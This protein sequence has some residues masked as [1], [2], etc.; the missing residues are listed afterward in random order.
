[1]TDI[2]D[3]RTGELRQSPAEQRVLEMLAIPDGLIGTP[4]GPAE[5]E[6][7]IEEFGDLVSHIARVIV[8]LYEDRHRA[9]EKYEA[10]FSDY[11]VMHEKSGALL[12]R[13]Y[14]T[15]KT[16]EERHELNVAKEA[17]RYAEE[18]QEAVKHRSYGLMNINKRFLGGS[19]MRG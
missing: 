2:V 9:E 15:S 16:K 14:A 18:M 8:L 10:A 11:C 5:I 17:L 12:A 7:K 19:G 6:K 4:I 1:M 13:Q 3:G